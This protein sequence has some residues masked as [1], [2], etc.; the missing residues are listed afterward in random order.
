M[1]LAVEAQLK[2]RKGEINKVN[3]LKI[4]VVTEGDE[5]PNDA[6]CAFSFLGVA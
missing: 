6:V 4:G 2:K 5:G 3:K 1:F